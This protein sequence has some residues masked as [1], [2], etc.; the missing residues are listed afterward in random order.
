MTN[1]KWKISKN[2]LRNGTG[3]VSVE[4]GGLIRITFRVVKRKS[5]GAY[6]VFGPQEVD[7][8]DPNKKYN[9]VYFIDQSD[10]KA[11]EAQLIHLA[12]QTDGECT[13]DGTKENNNDQVPF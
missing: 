8:K 9:S 13:A 5:D 11:L 12:K 3:M 10:R 2:W 7:R 4:F 6:F 1:S